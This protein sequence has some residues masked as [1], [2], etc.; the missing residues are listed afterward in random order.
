MGYEYELLTRLAKHLNLELE[1]KI[2]R[3]NDEM[4]IM[5]NNGEG[6]LVADNLIVTKRRKKIV[7][8]VDHLTTSSQV[9]IQRKPINWRNMKLHEIDAM[10]IRSPIDL[11]G[12][13]IHVAKVSPSINRLKNLSEELGAD[14]DIIVAPDSLTS[15]DLIGQVSNG[16]IDYTIEDEKIARLLQ[17]EYQN[18]DIN[19]PISLPQKIAWAVRKD[20]P[21][22]LNEI[23]N[24]LANIKKT[25]DYYVI[26]QKYFDNKYSFRKRYR[27]DYFS[28]TGGNISEYDNLIKEYANTLHWDWRLLASLIYQESQFRPNRTSTAG[29]TGLMQLMPATAQKFGIDSLSSTYDNLEAGVKYLKLLCKNWKAEIPDSSERMKFVMASYNIGQGHVEDAR[30]LAEKYGADKNIWFDNVEFYLLQKAY[31]KYYKDKVVRNGSAKGK[32]TAKY[33]RDIFYRYEHYQQ[34]IQ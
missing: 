1:I 27:S 20:S 28:M 8:F 33:V 18:I 34:F 11:V 9:L 16:E 23:N 19:L 17:F 29:A 31:P 3:T 6:D 14:I 12:K 25:T 21:L 30:K 15:E 10:L 5:L 22:L 24:W 26:Y 32:E 4:I 2:A 7:S 13:I